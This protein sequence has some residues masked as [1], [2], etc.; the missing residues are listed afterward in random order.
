[1][2]YRRL[3]WHGRE[4]Q[5]ALFSRLQSGLDRWLDA[6]SVEPACLDLQPVAA[7]ACKPAAPIKWLRADAKKC[8]LY[9]GAP[10]MH[11]E[12]L[13]GLLAKA[14]ADDILHLG[15]RVG[16]RALKALMAQWLD[17]AVTE[18]G[19]SEVSAPANDIFKGNFG[20][21][22]FTLK[23]AGF[24]AHV[25]FDPDAVDGL[26]PAK[27]TMAEPLAARDSV[28]GKEKIELNV[29]L[30]L[31]AAKLEDTLGLQV[32]DVLLSGTSIHS[33]FHLTHPDARHLADVRLVRKGRQ[34][35][36][37]IDTP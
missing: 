17:T 35:A 13:G 34:R 11:L 36:I 21:V 37:Q 16:D 25:V 8:V 31:G 14:S 4:R 7:D 1:M 3:R 12:G 29:M 24:A 30:D 26:V 9:F 10:A 15:R 2:H 27:N 33:V 5:E 32:G 22:F 19:V 20:Y 23:G 18:L 28:L 6:W